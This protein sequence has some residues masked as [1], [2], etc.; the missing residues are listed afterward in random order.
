MTGPLL[1]VP[2]APSPG[3]PRAMA[4]GHGAGHEP[5]P[6]AWWQVSRQYTLSQVH[7]SQVQQESRI[8][9]RLEVREEGRVRACAEMLRP[10]S[11]WRVLK[12]KGPPFERARGS[13]CPGMAGASPG[14]VSGQLRPMD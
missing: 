4:T 3:A 8:F 14:R 13:E 5:Y 6:P 11:A 12:L 9:P 10:D 1:F 2:N 7:T